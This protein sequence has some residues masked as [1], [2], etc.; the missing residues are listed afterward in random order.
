MY[1]EKTITVKDMV[2]YDGVKIKALFFYGNYYEEHITEIEASL[3]EGSLP[4]G[5]MK[6]IGSIPADFRNLMPVRVVISFE[7]SYQVAFG[8][9]YYK[10]KCIEKI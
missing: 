2:T 7:N 6:I 4:L 3:S 1:L 5:C 8:D 9:N 10:I